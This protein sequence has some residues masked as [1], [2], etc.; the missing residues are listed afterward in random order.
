MNEK[1]NG[2][3]VL[4]SSE[5]LPNEL[6]KFKRVY[7]ILAVCFAIGLIFG[8]QFLI[9]VGGMGLIGWFMFDC[10]WTKTKLLD[11]RNQRFR[12]VSGVSCDELF[13]VL[14]SS[15]IS[16]YGASMQVEKYYVGSESIVGVTYDN[17]IYE[18]IYINSDSTF[19]IRWGKSLGRAMAPSV[20]Y[21]DYKK[22]IIAMGMIGFELQKA[23]DIVPSANINSQNLAGAAERGQVS[24]LSYEN[25]GNNLWICKNCGYSNSA[26]GD[27]CVKCGHKK[28]Q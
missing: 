28:E 4:R 14:Q 20:S 8:I 6:E 2:V 12:F 18:I 25:N 21:S 10:T 22:A 7:I 17:I 11:L 1:I 16:R 15:L 9:T 13:N 26:D 3:W 27:Y 5:P 24:K 19:R 23:F